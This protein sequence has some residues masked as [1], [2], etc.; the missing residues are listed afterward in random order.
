MPREFC[1]LHLADSHIGADLPGR[2]RS[3]RRRRGDDLIDSYRDSAAQALTHQVDLVIHAGDV[4]DLP[5]PND[6]AL[7]AASEP[8]LRIASES[9]PVVIVPGNHERSVLPDCLLFA[10]PNLH[11][12]RE[13]TTL[14]FELRGRRV[15]VAAF[16]CIRR[17]SAHLFE[18]ALKA[19]DWRAARSDVNIL[20]VHQTFESATCGPAGFRFREGDDVVSRR[21]VPREFDYVAAGH[22]HRHQILETPHADGPPIVYA[23]SPDRVSFA[24]R[25]E[26]KGAVLIECNGSGLNHRFL[27]HAVRPMRLIPMNISGRSR[28][29]IIDS[30][31]EQI[32]SAPPETLVSLR[33]SGETTRRTLRGL[34]LARRL[35]A[36]RP[37]IQLAVSMQAVEFVPERRAVRAAK[38]RSTSAFARLAADPLEVI[39]LAIEERKTLPTGRGVYV[40]FDASGR[41][42]YVG[43]AKN[44][45]VR[46]R[47]HLS[48]KSNAGRFAGWPRQI[49]RVEV[50][51]ANSELEALLVEAELIYELRPPFNRQMRHWSRYCY[52]CE[53][54]R[55]HGQLHVCPDAAEDRLCF[56]PYRSRGGARMVL[57]AAA[58]LFQTANCP[59]EGVVNK[60][61]DRASAP[62]AACRRFYDG[63]CSA[64]C[65]N[66][67][68]REDYSRAICMRNALLTGLDDAPLVKLERQVEVQA[69]DE[70]PDE[71]ARR[72]IRRIRTLRETFDFAAAL[73]SGAR[74]LN[75]VIQ[76]PGPDGAS[77]TL[78]QISAGGLD[79]RVVQR[80]VQDENIAELIDRKRDEPADACVSKTIVDRLRTAC[81]ELRRLPERY[82]FISA[83]DWAPLSYVDGVNGSRRESIFR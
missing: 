45:R 57:D 47:S 69:S 35:R 43:K 44:V 54:G 83:A 76:A 41:V 11:I 10:H 6:A 82:R 68:A 23:G 24:E 80:F 16:P 25:D 74:L 30:V 32:H 65:A 34:Q 59:E 33:V 64:P 1:I 37:D 50:R 29:E 58:A 53:N 46:V 56:G 15:A 40:F 27:E 17:Q 55:P 78:I 19:A 21:L 75:G 42:L 73:R 61:T 36:E 70:A 39:D 9:I 77:C 38:M 31:V 2:P 8:L 48:P 20:A 67:I 51:A 3:K 4:F 13:P 12:V 5:N 26:P 7:A 18:Q 14:T 28:S 22:I 81:R 71:A 72:R 49:A 62:M 63:E 60:R 66:R 79:L 52:L